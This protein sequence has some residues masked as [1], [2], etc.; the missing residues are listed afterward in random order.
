MCNRKKAS[1]IKGLRV[2]GYRLQI[3]STSFNIFIYLFTK[4]FY[5][6]RKSGVKCV[7]EGVLKCYKASHIKDLRRLQMVTDG[8]AFLSVFFPL[9]NS[10]LSIEKT[11]YDDSIENRI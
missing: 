10:M 9:V 5:I 11:I 1:H 4:K 3:K 8:Y 6:K 7:T 2:I